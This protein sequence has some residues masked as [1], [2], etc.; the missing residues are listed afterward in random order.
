MFMPKARGYR[1]IIQGICSV[2]GWPEAQALTKENDKT[3]ASFIF[4]NILCRYGAIKQIVTDNGKPFIKAL[5]YL[6]SK[7]HIN[8]I[9]ISPYNSQAQG[10]VERSHFGLRESLIKACEK[11]LNEWPLKLPY[12]L[13]AQR[14]TTK[15]ATGHS[16]YYMVYGLEP[17]FPFDI[18][19]ATFLAPRLSQLVD[20]NTLIAERTKQLE[21]RPEELEEMKQKIWKKRRELA[22]ESLKKYEHTTKEYNF[23]PGHLVL[24]RNSGEESG[25]KNKYYPRYLGP[26][27]VVQQMKGGSYI[28]AEMDGTISKLRFAEKRVIPYHLRSQIKLPEPN[29]KINKAN[30]QNKTSI[31]QS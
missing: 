25:L 24:V 31:Y 15:K 23:M 13:W 7:Y 3:I 21:R 28:L 22:G 5:D 19:E 30:D 10:I 11:K 18:Q 14:I 8:H 4:N 9:L 1:Y 27:V 20:T 2:S 16:P 6:S 12:A 26:F 17:I 29:S